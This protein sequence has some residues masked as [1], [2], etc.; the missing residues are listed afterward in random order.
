M[1]PLV[2][3]SPP[4]RQCPHSEDPATPLPVIGSACWNW[5]LPAD[6]SPK[7]GCFHVP[8]VKGWFGRSR[9]HGSGAG[10]CTHR[11]LRPEDTTISLT[12]P[13]TLRAFRLFLTG[14][15]NE[16]TIPWLGP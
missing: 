15:R 16:I 10:C 14:Q 12:A 3:P 6:S 7:S 5:R 11:P 8:H 13:F 9:D 2:S 1:T 4:S